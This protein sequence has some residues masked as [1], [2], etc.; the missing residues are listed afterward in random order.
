MTKRGCGRSD[1]IDGWVSQDLLETCAS[2]EPVS[3]IDICQIGITAIV[4]RDVPAVDT[5]DCAHRQL[6]AARSLNERSPLVTGLPFSRT[7]T[8]A[9]VYI[10][11]LVILSVLQFSDVHVASLPI[12]VR[13]ADALYHFLQLSTNAGK[14]GSTLSGEI[15]GGHFGGVAGTLGVPLDQRVSGKS[16]LPPML[17]EWAF[18]LT[19]EK[20]MSKRGTFN[21]VLKLFSGIWLGL[22]TTAV[23]VFFDGRRWRL[24]RKAE[25]LQD[26][27]TNSTSLCEPVQVET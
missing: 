11:D 14:S 18:A 10:D 1:D 15:W 19:G 3:E 17:G 25:R 6:L 2:F 27:V 22:L 5:L 4:V 16:D 21:H 23:M 12:E 13:R 20:A 7:K 8:V 26:D 9:D 24:S